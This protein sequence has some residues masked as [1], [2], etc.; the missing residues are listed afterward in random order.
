MSDLDKTDSK[1]LPRLPKTY[2]G[3][4]TRVKSNNGNAIEPFIIGGSNASRNEYPE[5]TIVL[6]FNADFTEIIGS[7][8]G[9]LIAENKVL[10][11]GHCSL[12]SASSYAMVP[13]FYNFNDDLTADDVFFAN[14]VVTHPRFNSTT[15]DYDLAVITLSS[16]ASSATARIYRGD[17]D[18][19]GARGTSIGVGAVSTVDP[20]NRLFPDI[21][22][23]IT[24]PIIN[25]QACNDNWNALIG[26]R[27]IT[28]RMMCSGFSNNG[29]GV[30]SGDSGGALWTT[31]DGQR[32]LVGS[33]SFGLVPCEFNRAT[34]TYARLSAL[35]SFIQTQSPRTSFIPAD[36][37]IIM[38]PI[39]SLLLD[40]E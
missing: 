38:A 9:T 12:E 22:Q 20:N 26:D 39:N 8:G 37:P 33:V 24:T 27:P 3:A 16:N 11:A 31:I 1:V 36:D 29:N 32:A 40:E 4:N 34:Q 35:T 17:D 15:F 28:D 18:F 23:E 7:C 10:T 21:L 2:P 25:N 13:N 5:Y 6:I 30:C 19:D 14:S